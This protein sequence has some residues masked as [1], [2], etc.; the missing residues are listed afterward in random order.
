MNAKTIRI[1]LVEDD[2]EDA[3]LFQFMLARE[4]NDEFL[5]TRVARLADALGNL[6]DQVYDVVLSDMGLP[7]S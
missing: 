2:P 4:A 3:R 5:L 6:K 7:D 1:L